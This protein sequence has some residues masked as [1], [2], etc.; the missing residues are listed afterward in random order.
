MMTEHAF[1]KSVKR[2]YA[3]HMKF[4]LP[5]WT[6]LVLAF[7]LSVPTEAEAGY[8]RR[9]AYNYYPPDSSLPQPPADQ[10]QNS[11]ARPA[12]P[13]Q[14]AEKQEPFKEVPVNSTFYFTA[15]R[16]KSF[17]R[18]KISDTTARS[19]KDGKVSQVPPATVVVVGSETNKVA[20]KA[21]ANPKK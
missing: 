7:V 16:N 14:P 19:V 21:A 1:E 2:S 4:R 17:P 20:D 6:L 13:K 5:F 9:R 3:I 10:N 12:Q 8:G 15:D 11:P 18:I